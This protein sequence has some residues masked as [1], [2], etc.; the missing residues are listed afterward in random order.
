[1]AIY[2]FFLGQRFPCCY[3]QQEREREITEKILT[4]ISHISYTWNNNNWIFSLT[5]RSHKK[6]TGF[7]DPMFIFYVSNL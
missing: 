2:Y 7:L 3:M 4:T 1:M 5:L 6:N